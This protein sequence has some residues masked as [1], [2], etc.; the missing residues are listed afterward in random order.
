[1]Q[2]SK[3]IPSEIRFCFLVIFG[4]SDLKRLQQQNTAYSK[5]LFNIVTNDD[6][7]AL[8]YRVFGFKYKITERRTPSNP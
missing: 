8:S 3:T 4:N 2:R 1:M 5:S 6:T 7:R